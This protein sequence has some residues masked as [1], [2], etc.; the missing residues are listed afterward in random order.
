[1]SDSSPVVFCVHYSLAAIIR[2]FNAAYFLLVCGVW[3]W[4]YGKK[5]L[6]A[7]EKAMQE[8]SQANKYVWKHEANNY[9]PDVEM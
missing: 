7:A 5:D 3:L 8:Q 2:G 1:M 6:S 9:L 4:G